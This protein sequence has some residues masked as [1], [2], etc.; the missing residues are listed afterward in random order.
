MKTFKTYLS[1]LLLSFSI[2]SYT[3]EPTA[4]Y[5]ETEATITEINFKVRS[6]RSSATATVDYVT[7]EGDSLSSTVKL[8]HIP[9]IGPLN[10]EGDKITVLY[11][12]ATPLIL[13]TSKTSFIQSYGLY[14]LIAM[15]LLIFVYRFIKRSKK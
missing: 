3:Q 9:F 1:L 15:G 6:R 12:K 7:K 11:N 14:L 4:E 8:F 13:T 10:N 5:I 2:V